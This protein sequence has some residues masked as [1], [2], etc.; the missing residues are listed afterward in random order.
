MKKT[1]IF[2]TAV[3]SVLFLCC[4]CSADNIDDGIA[5][6]KN[7]DDDIREDA[8]EYLGSVGGKRVEDALLE[9]MTDPEEDVRQSAVEAIGKVGGSK[10]VPSLIRALS[11][12]SF[13]VRMEAIKSLGKI[14]DASAIDPLQEIAGSTINPWISQKASKAI[15]KIKGRVK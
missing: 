1:G 8:V 5:K 3:V 7:P 11:D 6:L 12:D 14:G 9:A 13:G 15:V 4:H 10:A 2:L